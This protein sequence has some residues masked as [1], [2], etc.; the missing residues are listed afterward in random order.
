M[1]I[2]AYVYKKKTCS[3]FLNFFLGEKLNLDYV[4]EK[5]VKIACNFY[6]LVNFFF[7]SRSKFAT[8]RDVPKI[9]KFFEKFMHIFLIF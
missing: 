2:L 4:I 3:M 6:H 5:I 1:F 7:E 8:K 9:P